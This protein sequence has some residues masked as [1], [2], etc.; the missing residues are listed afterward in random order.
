[1]NRNQWIATAVTLATGVAVVAFPPWRFGRVPL[2]YHPQWPPHSSPIRG[3][4]GY[5]PFSFTVDAP[6]LDRQTV[7]AINAEI[8][9]E[10]QKPGANPAKDSPEQQIEQL[11]ATFQSQLQIDSAR[12]AVMLGS[13][14]AVGIVLVILLRDRRNA[15]APAA[16]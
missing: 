1:M 4:S 8:Q 5:P 7:Q 9:S 11:G 15:P 12:L 6:T 16:E 3:L 13:L 14:A 10:F 2:P